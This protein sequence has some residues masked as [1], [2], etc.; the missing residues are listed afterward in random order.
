MASLSRY[1][2]TMGGR[3][4]GLPK[5]GRACV[6]YLNAMYVSAVVH[7]TEKNPSKP[8]K[9]RQNP[10]KPVNYRTTVDRIS[11]EEKCTRLPQKPK[12]PKTNP[13]RAIAHRP[14]EKCP[15]Q[16][17]RGEW[18]RRLGTLNNFPLQSH[19]F[20][21]LTPVAHHEDDVEGCECLC[22]FCPWSANLLF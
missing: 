12:K 14:A 9:T 13:V 18:N 8:V 16:F 15:Q 7:Y 2:D 6:L 21:C 20:S 10:S 11:L 17:F 4:L 5:S 3:R 19:S 22:L 1:Q